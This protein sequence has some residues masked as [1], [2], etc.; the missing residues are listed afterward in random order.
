MV[1]VAKLSPEQWE[2]IRRKREVDRVSYRVLA[3][4]YGVSDAA[5]I[6][7]A[8]RDDW[9]SKTDT[10]TQEKV[11]ANQDANQ[12]ANQLA[13]LQTIPLT[14]A[15][16]VERNPDEFGVF[17][18]LNDAE[19]VFV[20]EYLVDWNASAAAIRAG[21]S[22][23][24]AH[25]QAWR[26]LKNE[27]VRAAVQT[28]ASA[29]ARRLGIDGDELMRLWAAIVTFDA[30]EISQLRRVCCPYC[31][32]KEHRPT[33]STSSTRKRSRPWWRS[34]PPRCVP[35]EGFPICWPSGLAWWRSG[36]RKT[37]AATGTTAPGGPH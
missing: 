5:I 33:P 24:S 26:L 8:K 30:N 32:G 3:A 31:W 37:R 14:T 4:E 10:P 23:A 19:E 13:N 18:D 15:Q 12:N 6:K 9:V 28:L 20:R 21:Y 17:A 36:C 2:E 22:A 34:V 7:R 29:R 35:T 1:A 27:K 11:S 25:T 16:A